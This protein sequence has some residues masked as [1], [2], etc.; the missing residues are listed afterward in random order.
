LIDIFEPIHN[1]ALKTSI[2]KAEIRE[3]AAKKCLKRHDGGK[4]AKENA[5][6]KGLR[7]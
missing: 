1:V 3:D 4:G 2:I 5:P 6:S 7:H